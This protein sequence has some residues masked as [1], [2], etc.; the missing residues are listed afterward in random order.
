[1]PRG[2]RRPCPHP[3]SLTQQRVTQRRVRAKVDAVRRGVR[4]FL[5]LLPRTAAAQATRVAERRLD[6]EG[7]ALVTGPGYRKGL[8]LGKR[9]FECHP[10]GPFLGE[11]VVSCTA[12]ASGAT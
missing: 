5:I 8:V 10:K 3:G 4:E 1:M 7:A 12:G 11:G 9:P 6:V 2:P